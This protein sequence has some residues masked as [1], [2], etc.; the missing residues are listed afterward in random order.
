MIIAGSIMFSTCAVDTTG[1]SFI[2]WTVSL[3][4]IGRRCFTIGLILGAVSVALEWIG[5]YL[6]KKAEK[7]KKTEL[8]P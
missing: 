4:G 8:A 3:S 1:N 6:R 7:E 5:Y 2:G